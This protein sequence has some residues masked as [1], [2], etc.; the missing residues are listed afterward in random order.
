MSSSQA[1]VTFSVAF[2]G[3]QVPLVLRAAPGQL[4][5]GSP[6]RHMRIQGREQEAKQQ[7]QQ[8]HSAYNHNIDEAIQIL[9]VL[10]LLGPWHATD[11][12]PENCS[13]LGYIQ[14]INNF[15]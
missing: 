2:E 6:R 12:H 8:D 10:I 15:K 5:P 14:V 4:P 13:R 9:G 3:F 7:E 11:I 1:H